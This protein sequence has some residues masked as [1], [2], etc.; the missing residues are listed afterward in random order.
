MN[1]TII[2]DAGTWNASSLLLVNTT[3]KGTALL[4]LA[5]IVAIFLRRDSAATRHLV[6]LLAIVAILVV[7]I[8][9]TILPRWRVLP[10]W[11]GIAPETAPVETDSQYSAARPIPGTRGVT[12][13]GDLRAIDRPRTTPNLHTADL[14]QARPASAKPAVVPGATASSGNWINALSIVWAIG[15][16]VLILRLLAA[17]LMLWK[18]ERQATVVWPSG[19]PAESIHDP[20]VT[21]LEIALSQLAI[22]RPVTLL[23]HPDQTVPIVWGVLRS[24]LLV[25]PGARLW[26]GEQLRSVLLHE[27]AHVKR[28][29][30]MVQLLAAIATAVHWFNP[31]MWFTAWRLGVECERACDDLVLASGVRPSA[32]AAHLLDVV[33]GISPASWSQSCGLA[34]AR[35]SSLEGRLIAILGENSNRRGVSAPL[36]VFA[37]VIAVG[38]AAPV[39]MLRAAGEKPGEPTQGQ[40]SQKPN[41]STKFP[42]GTEEK[43]SWGEPVNGLRAA[44]II[45]QTSDK[46]KPGDKPDLYLA[47]QN[48]SNAPIRLADTTA[49]PELRTLYIK[50]YGKIMAALADMQPSL[51]DVI[52]Q[53]RDVVSLVLFPVGLKNPNERTPGSFVADDTLHDTHQTLVAHLTI[54]HAPAGAWTGKLVT[55]ETSGAVA[56]GKPQLEGKEAQALFKMWQDQARTN[57]NIPGGL[58][59][60]LGDK[61]NEFIRLNTGDA[62]GDPYAKKM[63]SLVP[64]FNT[65]RDWTPAEAMVLLDD[66]TVVT[67][68]PLE[69]AMEEA[70]TRTI[71]PGSPLL[72]E[73]TKAPWGEA[74]PNGLRMAWVLEPHADQHRLGTPLRSRILIHNAGHNTVVFRTR[75]WHQSGSHKARDAKGAALNIESTDWM[76]IAPLV[77]FRLAPGEFIDVSAAGIGVGANKDDE[78]WQGTRVGSWIEAKEGDEVTF[79]PDSVP[80]CDWNEAPPRDGERGW[81]P[82][83]IT[84]RLHRDLPLPTAVDERTHLLYRAMRDLFGAAPTAEETTAFTADTSPAALDSLARRLIQR[85]GLTSFT[86]RLTSGTTTFRVLPADPDAAKKP[87]TANNPG[88]YTLGENVR[89][90]VSRR[91]DGTRIVSEASI[92]FFSPD[93]TRPPPGPPHEIKLPDGY[94]TWAAAWMRGSN[95][96]WV[97]QKGSIRSYDFTDP[98]GVKETSL[99]LPVNRKKVPDPIFD[100]LRAMVDVFEAPAT[101]L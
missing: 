45:R 58:I 60:R 34:M 85:P 7:P 100:A 71:R 1:H 66:I 92:Q 47:L 8:L 91:P 72:P 76:T 96:L 70:T 79:T 21:A 90:I 50:H 24:R 3:I 55:G 74:L 44:I 46:P 16:F 35:K 69:T 6:W 22:H 53:P 42:P 80:L 84:E 23:I 18:S 13:N 2:I 9:S 38:I 12:Q 49:A 93:P 75:T 63:A 101:S 59:A 29:D 87:R 64:R 94:N 10:A 88:R 15:F 20:V 78:D 11:A 48:V 68:I 37:V 81:W 5:T 65:T 26:T 57:G 4:L 41:G 95:V 54:E 17:R 51:A 62:S 82:A 52:V 61:V 39:A 30:T 97:I 33:T 73:R 56:M 32:Y 40:E 28:R 98:A 25:P 77:P 19:R 86:G 31:L 27:L 99:E 83:F 43:L 89:L 14:E 67:P 36:A